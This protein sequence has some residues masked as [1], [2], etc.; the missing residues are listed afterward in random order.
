MSMGVCCLYAVIS[1][2]VVGVVGYSHPFAKGGVLLSLSICVG[3][4]IGKMVSVWLGLVLVMVYAGGMLVLFCYICCLA[5]SCLFP[6]TS[7][8][9][10]LALLVGWVVWIDSVIYVRCWQSLP[11]KGAWKV[12]L[13]I[14]HYGIIPFLGCVLC[15]VLMGVCKMSQVEKGPLRVFRVK[16]CSL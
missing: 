6:P 3:M 14:D 15:L 1:W 7:A 12:C 4:C 13:S 5:S 2:L 9:W 16:S 10:F 8:W 11:K